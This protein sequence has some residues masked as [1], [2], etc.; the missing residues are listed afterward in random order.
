MTA[1]VRADVLHPNNLPLWY[2]VYKT[3]P[4]KYEPKY[5]RKSPTTEIQNIF[6]QEDLIRA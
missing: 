6:Y 5:N 3:F 2:E 4:P 1:L